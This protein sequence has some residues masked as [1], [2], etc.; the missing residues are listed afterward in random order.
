M[1]LA[2]AEGRLVKLGVLVADLV[3]VALWELLGL[4]L[5]STVMLGV[6]VPIEL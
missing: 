2:D 1:R 6:L 5:G 3:A 4:E